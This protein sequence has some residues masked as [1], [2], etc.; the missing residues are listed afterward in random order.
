MITEQELR[1]FIEDGAGTIDTP[2]T[3]AQIAGASAAFDWLLPL[4]APQEGQPPRYRVG[5]IGEGTL[6]RQTFPGALR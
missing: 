6:D 2:L 3:E 1:Q 4:P 5:V